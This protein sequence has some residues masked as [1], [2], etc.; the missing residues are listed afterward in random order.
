MLLEFIGHAEQTYAFA[1]GNALSWHSG[2]HG[3]NLGD[4]LLV[5]C[6]ATTVQFL[7]PM[8]LGNS[9]LMLELFLLVTV[10]G[11]TL[12][13]LSLYGLELVVLGLGDALL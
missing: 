6:D 9:K 3:D 7:L 4:V 10:T 13:V 12:K 2:H 8:F 5:D 1:L 11:C